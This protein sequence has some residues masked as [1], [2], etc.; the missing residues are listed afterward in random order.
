MY[1]AVQ[2]QNALAASMHNESSRTPIAVQTTGFC[3]GLADCDMDQN[4][5]AVH[6]LQ[7]GNAYLQWAY[8][9]ESLSTIEGSCMPLAVQGTGFAVA[10]RDGNSITILLLR[11]HCRSPQQVCNGCAHGAIDDRNGSSCATT[12]HTFAVGTHSHTDIPSKNS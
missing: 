4:P 3:S 9:M 5:A 12:A 2:A 7:H 11:A 10:A 1:I 6:T 8:E